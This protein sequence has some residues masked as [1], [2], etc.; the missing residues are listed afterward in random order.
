MSEKIVRREFLKGLSG[1][2]LSRGALPGF[3]GAALAGCGESPLPNALAMIY[4]D[5]GAAVIV[6][7]VYLE[8]FPEE[9]NVEILVAQ[10]VGNQRSRLRK[11]AMDQPALLRALAELHAA[12]FKEDRL[13]TV[14]RWVLSRTEARLCALA[15]K[16]R[17]L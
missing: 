12:D 15:A 1:L 2:A 7:R 4:S 8:Q 11:L 9:A 16:A 17:G 5:P 3:A 10:I 14:D 6:G 13:V